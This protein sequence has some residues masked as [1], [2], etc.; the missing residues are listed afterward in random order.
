MRREH[1]AREQ[2]LRNRLD[3]FTLLELIEEHKDNADAVRTL[4]YLLDVIRTETRVLELQNKEIT[5]LWRDQQLA[6]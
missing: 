2:I 4:G 1:S 3:E 6:A 5:Q